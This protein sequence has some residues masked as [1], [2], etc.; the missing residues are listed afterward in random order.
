[1]ADRGVESSARAHWCVLH[2]SST[3]QEVAFSVVWGMAGAA[4]VFQVK[5]RDAVHGGQVVELQV[6]GCEWL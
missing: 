6:S 2:D 5:H 4:R 3:L 1:M